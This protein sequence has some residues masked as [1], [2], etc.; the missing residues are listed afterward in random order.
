MDKITLY[1]FDNEASI[2]KPKKLEEL[3]KKIELNFLLSEQ[4]SKLVKILYNKGISSICIKDDE[5]LEKC[6]K[7]GV[8]N[9]YLDIDNNPEIF[10]DYLKLKFNLKDENDLEKLRNCLLEEDKIKYKYNNSFKSD[11]NK[12][13]MLEE[14]IQKMVQKLS[15]LKKKVKEGK[16]SLEIKLNDIKKDITELKTKL[17]LPLK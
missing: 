4:Q 5:S 1:L 7:S 14:N 6:I 8:T 2:D 9:L 17:G 13:K 16:D 11:E 10:E 3:R 15:S 12:I